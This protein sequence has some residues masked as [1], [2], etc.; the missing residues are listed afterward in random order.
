M[1]THISL[2]NRIF[3][4][5]F[6]IGGIWA[7]IHGRW[8]LVV[9]VALGLTYA[10]STILRASR[11]SLSDTARLDIGQPADERDR[12]LLDRALAAVGLAALVIECALFLYRAGG[13]DP[14]TAA[15]ESGI[16]LAGLAL[17]WVIANRVLVR[18]SA[19]HG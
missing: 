14:A 18:R 6:V 4:V 9:L 3:I 15:T 7:A 8:S 12:L 19:T 11:G 1:T 2:L 16:R 13:P 17:V 5:V 10:A